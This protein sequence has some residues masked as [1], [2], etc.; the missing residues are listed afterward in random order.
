[1]EASWTSVEL[2]GRECNGGEA[3]K[4]F[5]EYGLAFKSDGRI[6]DT[7]K[8]RVIATHAAVGTPWRSSAA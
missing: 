4:A 6:L 2:A 7:N 5:K 8:E 1:M 3:I